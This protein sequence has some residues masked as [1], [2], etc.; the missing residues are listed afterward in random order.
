VAPPTSDEN[1]PAHLK[2]RSFLYG[3]ATN[4]DQTKWM[5]D[6]LIAEQG[7]GLISGQ[8]GVY[9][10]FTAI[11]LAKCVIRGIPF[12]RY[13]ILRPG[14]VLFLAYEAY[15]TIDVRVRAAVEQSYEVPSETPRN[16]PFKCYDGGPQLLVDPKATVREL[17]EIIEHTKKLF[18][19]R[20]TRPLVMVIIDTA[21]A[22]A[23][24]REK[25]DENDSVL[26]QRIKR[27]LEAVAKQHHL[28][29]FLVDHRG[30]N[31]ATG[32]RGSSAKD[33]WADTILSL[34]GENQEGVIANPR[35][36]VAK[37]KNAPQGAQYPIRLRKV[38]VTL[39][40]ETVQTV[41]IDWGR[42]QEAILPEDDK[43][44]STKGL[45]LL[46]QVLMSVMVAEGEEIEPKRS[47]EKVRAVS[48]EKIREPF[49]ELYS[50]PETDPK[51]AKDARRKALSRAI[52]IG[53]EK[54][55]IGFIRTKDDREF[56]WIVSKIRPA[57]VV[58]EPQ[59]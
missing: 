59:E 26:G 34:L 43:V 58:V 15:E 28:F 38:D 54:K 27:I 47:G 46:R 17:T 1:L 20:F 37:V 35:L 39:E 19:E 44:W 16:M 41:V 56:V 32:T 40:G 11:E 53:Q 13:P 14:G 30:K 9:K 6:Q 21:M 52:D 24:Y 18:E 48:V 25:G 57:H 29:I 12:V 3:E 8:W 10:T 49:Y 7:V 31:P 22:A 36:G 33:A 2:Y 55:L 23:G 4:A 50:S 51:K 5:V 45:K 42:E